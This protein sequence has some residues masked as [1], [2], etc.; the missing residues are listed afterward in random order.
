[1]K[2]EIDKNIKTQKK[3][4]K[5]RVVYWNNIPTPYMVERFNAVAERIKEE[6]D[7]LVSGSVPE[8]YM[9]HFFSE[10]HLTLAPSRV[11]TFG[12]SIV[13]SMLSETPVITS[14]L[15]THKVLELPVLYASNIEEYVEKVYSIKEMWEYGPEDYV[16]LIKSCRKEALK[17]DKMFIVGQLENMFMEVFNNS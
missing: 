5:P 7:I 3:V 8:E 2:I 16:S 11:D 9:P 1:M 15:K 13:E 17:F 4:K 14:P 12:L 6:T 10:A